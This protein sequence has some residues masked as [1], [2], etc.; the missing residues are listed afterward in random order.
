MALAGTA[1]N[2]L[3]PTIILGLAGAAYL[4]TAFYLLRRSDTAVTYGIVVP[5]ARLI[6]DW[7]GILPGAQLF[8][9]ALIV[10]DL[11]VIAA[12]VYLYMTG[13]APIRRV[14]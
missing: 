10:I 9:T 1:A 3:L 6:A 12:C 13:R 4:I 5:A 7:M 2:G 8:G 14:R 11:I